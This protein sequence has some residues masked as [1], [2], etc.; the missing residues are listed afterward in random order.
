MAATRTPILD[1]LMQDGTIVLREHEY[2][3]VAADGTEVC[4]GA[5]FCLKDVRRIEAYLQ[6]NPEPHNW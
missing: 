5:A 2:F 3:G 1:R 6:G 4:F